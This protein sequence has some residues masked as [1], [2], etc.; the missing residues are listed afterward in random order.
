[1][2]LHSFIHYGLSWNIF[3]DKPLQIHLWP[4]QMS[5]KHLDLSDCYPIVYLS[6]VSPENRYKS[7]L[8]FLCNIQIFIQMLMLMAGSRILLHLMWLIKTKNS[9]RLKLFIHD[10]SLTQN[11]RLPTS[12]YA[13]ISLFGRSKVY[14]CALNNHVHLHLPHLVCI[15]NHLLSLLSIGFLSILNV[16]QREFTL[17]TVLFC[18]VFSHDMIQ[19]IKWSEVT[20]CK[21]HFRYNI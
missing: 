19:P 11:T 15:S 21:C 1:M 18:F 13:D 12:K 5:L 4:I 8:L 6:N 20:K 9:R 2:N 17:Y 16:P 7:D 10:Y 14:S 3:K